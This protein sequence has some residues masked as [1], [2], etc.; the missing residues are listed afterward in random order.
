M[1][2]KRQLIDYL[3]GF[4]DDTLILVPAGSPDYWGNQPLSE[5]S[6]RGQDTTTVVRSSYHNGAYVAAREG[7]DRDEDDEPGTEALILS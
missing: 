7:R 4:P 6:L 3:E 1:T 2:T 5:L